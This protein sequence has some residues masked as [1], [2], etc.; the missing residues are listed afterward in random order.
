MKTDWTRTGGIRDISRIPKIHCLA[1]LRSGQMGSV[2]GFDNIRG[3]GEF[4]SHDSFVLFIGKSF[5]RYKVFDLS[6]AFSRGENFFNLMLFYSINDIRRWRRRNL[7]RGELGYV[8]R[9]K[10]TFMED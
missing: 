8:I 1:R 2:I 7:L 10:E 5:P 6:L 4:V 9:M 3:I